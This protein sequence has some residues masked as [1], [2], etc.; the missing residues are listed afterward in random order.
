MIR[1]TVIALAAAAAAAHGAAAEEFTGEIR[2]VN[3]GITDGRPTGSVTVTVD[4]DDFIVTIAAAGF[5]E[6]MHLAHLHGFPGANPAEASC[7]TPEADANGDG[8]VDLVETRD[9]S[10]VTMIPI[11]DDPASL[12][13]DADTYPTAD[14]TGRM[15]QLTTARL[16]AL[17]EA[18][19][20]SFDGPPAPGTR[21]V[22]FHGVPEGTELLDTVQSLEGVP[23]Q[24]T[25]PIACAELA[26]AS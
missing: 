20:A 17:T 23:A 14:E 8:I 7:A 21:V 2:A 16:A 25:V 5:P 3:E 26:P 22:Y 10:G 15:Y 13:I 18:V 9:V 11:T 1:T 24:V 4:G 19:Q 6:G 12:E